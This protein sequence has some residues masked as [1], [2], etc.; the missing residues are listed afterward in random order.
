MGYVLRP[1]SCCCMLRTTEHVDSD[2]SGGI[3]VRSL[4]RDVQE[5][6]PSHRLLISEDWALCRYQE[7]LT[8]RTSNDAK[9]LVSREP[10]LVESRKYFQESVNAHQAD[11]QAGGKA[12]GFVSP[13]YP[14]CAQQRRCIDDEVQRL[15]TALGEEAPVWQHEYIC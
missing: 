10:L 2:T 4:V 9:S 15:V 7:A 1:G 3:I 11:S 8:H 14:A 13:Y 5:P 6:Q 12:C